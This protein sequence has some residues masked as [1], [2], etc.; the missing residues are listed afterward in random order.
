MRRSSVFAARALSLAALGTLVSLSPAAAVS[1]T[2]YESQVV[3]RTNTFRSS[4]DL[5]KVKSHS[6]VDRFAES[7]AKRMARTGTFSHQD[8]GRILDTC[9]LTMVSENIA[10]GYSSGNKTV[11]AWMKSPGH[12][13]NILTRKMRYVGVGAVQDDNGRWYVAQVFGTKK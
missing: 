6:C 7:N 4:H 13:K 3:K 10:Y 12:R 5:V 11:N 2:T 9:H 1:S 8:L